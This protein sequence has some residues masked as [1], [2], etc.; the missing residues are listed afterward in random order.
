[1]VSGWYWAEKARPIIVA[2]ACMILG[3]NHPGIPP[4]VSVAYPL[5]PS[6]TSTFPPTVNCTPHTPALQA[7]LDLC[8]KQERV[9]AGAS[10]HLVAAKPLLQQM[11]DASPILAQVSAGLGVSKPDNGSTD[12]KGQ[13]QQQ[14]QQQQ[15]QQQPEPEP[16]SDAP[17]FVEN[18]NRHLLGPAPPR[19]VKVCGESPPYLQRGGRGR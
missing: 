12:K 8:S 3:E 15:K 19:A 10:K 11:L 2:I 1:M 17:G 6:F 18:V 16:P 14:Q 4:P 9:L 13:Q 7:L 5:T